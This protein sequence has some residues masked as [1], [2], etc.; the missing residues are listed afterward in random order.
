[1]RIIAFRLSSTSLF[2][3]A[4]EDT[5]IR[6]AVFPC[7]TVPPHQHVPPSWTRPITSRRFSGGLY[8]S[9]FEGLNDLEINQALG[10]LCRPEVTREEIGRVQEGGKCRGGG[11]VWQG[12]TAKL[13]SV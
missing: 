4:Q 5:L 8:E 3:V 6:I 13:R 12:K 1:M 9:G 7:Q 11:K 2:V 10:S